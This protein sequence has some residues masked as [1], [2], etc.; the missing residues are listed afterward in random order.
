MSDNLRSL[1]KEHHAFYEVLPCYLVLEERHVSSSV[2]T[3]RVQAG[4][5][6]ELYGV[7]IRDEFVVPGP[8][9]HYA[10][11]YAQ[12]QKIVEK[13]SHR[14]DHSC[15]LKVIP[16]HSTFVLDSRNQTVEAMIR[17][18]ISH[19]RGIDQPAGLAEQ[20]ALEEIENQLH[21]L[22]ITRR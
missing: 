4:F 7:N 5:D 8:D 6:V 17:I 21:G 13:V 15:S 22:G 20:H 11:A 3:R 18:R 2:V 16:F 9:P 14:V 10:L 19:R 12:L 1:I